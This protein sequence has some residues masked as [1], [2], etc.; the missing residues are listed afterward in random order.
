M[1]KAWTLILLLIACSLQAQ[2]LVLKEVNKKWESFKKSS[3]VVDFGVAESTK[4][5]NLVFGDSYN[6]KDQI[7]KVKVE[8]SKVEDGKLVI[9]V[10]FPEVV[11][12][13]LD[14]VSDDEIDYQLV[15]RSV[16]LPIDPL[17]TYEVEIRGIHSVQ[18]SSGSE[19]KRKKAQVFAKMKLLSKSEWLKNLQENFEVEDNSTKEFKEFL[20][21]KLTE[22]KLEN[23]TYERLGAQ[24]NKHFKENGFDLIF[25]QRNT[26]PDEIKT[27]S[28]DHKNVS[29]KEL[30]QRIAHIEKLKYKIGKKEVIIATGEAF[31]RS[32]NIKTKDGLNLP[33]LK[34][35]IKKQQLILEA[36]VCLSSG[37]LEYLMCLPNSFEHESVFMTEVKPELIHM[38]LLLIQA[39][40][41]PYKDRVE[42]MQELKGN[43]SRLKIV[44]HWEE[45]KKK[46]AVDLNKLLIDRTQTKKKTLAEDLWF[47]S[48]SYFTEG[49]VYA[50]NIHKSVVSLQQHPAS[51]IQ[52]GKETIDPYKSRKAGF[53]VNEDLCPPMNAKVKI[54][55]TVHP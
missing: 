8:S 18:T 26:D 21:S 41:L 15:S 10:L 35:D 47:F 55:I 46:H 36:K 37:I 34:V 22:F 48:G 54:I 11:L 42:A 44:V 30:V 40:K 27:F 39:K 19:F 38:G 16:N 52:Y 24:L 53:E 3:E 4:S 12:E 31:K 45:D 13:L 43:K 1:K 6:E 51:V 14:V 32:K 28:L 20:S 7:R 49:N 25:M 2:P 9:T 33:G 17:E 5:L 50:A 29:I 23:A